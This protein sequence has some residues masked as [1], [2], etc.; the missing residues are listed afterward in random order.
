MEQIQINNLYS[1]DETIAKEYLE[2]LEQRLYD[3]MAGFGCITKYISDDSGED[4]ESDEDI[5]RQSSF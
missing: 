3:D 4:E 5:R 2:K 1:L